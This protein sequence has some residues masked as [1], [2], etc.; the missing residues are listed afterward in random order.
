MGGAALLVSGISLYVAVHH[1]QTMEKLVEAN[2]FPNIE[3]GTEIVDGVQPGT[4]DFKIVF[5]N[6]GVG[7]ARVETVQFWD[8]NA[9]VLSADQ[10]ASAIKAEGDGRPL[11][12]RLGGETVVGSLI[13]AGKTKD[14][15]SLEVDRA[16]WEAPAV[17]YSSR[18][19][20]RVCYCS[21][22]DECYV[23]D[24]KADR[25]RPTYVKTCPAASSQYQDDVSG[26]LARALA[27]QRK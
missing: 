16:E 20:S 7:P 21:V 19:R 3:V 8:G 15:V 10:I 1:G 14:L 18:L 12:A 24:S 6:T 2:S 25:G 23:T 5:D 26:L 17:R 27:S 22:F 11:D 4:I 9:P 13:G